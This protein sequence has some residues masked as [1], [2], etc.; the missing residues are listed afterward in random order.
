[1]SG[2]KRI[3]ISPFLLLE[4]V[5][6]GRLRNHEDV[7]NLF[8]GGWLHARYYFECKRSVAGFEELGLLKVDS[9]GT[10]R[11]TAKVELLLETFALSP[12]QMSIYS[13]DSLLVNPIFGRPPTQDSG[14][15]IFVLMPL[16]TEMRSIYNDHIKRVAER[17]G[18][19]IA[20]ADD[21]FSA[22]A[23]IDDIWNAINGAEVIIADCTGQNPNV[24]YEIGVA[25]TLGK[26]VITISRTLDDIPFDVAHRR[27]IS[28]ETT[29][30]GMVHFEETLAR[31]LESELLHSDPID[32]ANEILNKNYADSST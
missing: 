14:P 7:K 5:R 8:Y 24:F 28:Y 25:H 15:N 19:S 29:T 10:F 1:M 18:K 11:L 16:A 27:A 20:R 22:S 4:A 30:N 31:T 32:S 6:D 17:L 2:P 26:P 3:S 12:S 13:Q 9:N 23:I 21:F